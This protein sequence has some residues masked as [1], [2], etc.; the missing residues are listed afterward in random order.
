M[1]TLITGLGYIGSALAQRLLRSGE[2]VVGIENFFST[3]REAVAALAGYGDFRLVDGSVDDSACLARAFRTAPIARVVHLAGQASADPSAAPLRYTIDTYVGGA[4]RLLEGCI[5]HRVDHL[6]FAS[7]TRI[8]APPLPS[9]TT[10]EAPLHA[11]DIVHV[12]QL[13]AESMLATALQ[14]HP[15]WSVNALT[16]RIGNVHGRGPVMKDDP[17]F[18]GVA[19]RFC[20]LAA[21]RQPLRASTAPSS[22]LA[23]V[24]LDDVV[25]GLIHCTHLQDPP[26][27]ANLATEI[28]SVH[29]VAL[30]VQRLAAER[31]LDVG[32]T[33][34]GPPPLCEA[35]TVQSRLEATGFRPRRTLEDSLDA[36][37][38]H[39]LNR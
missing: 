33:A 17:R 38:D 21:Q 10:E 8:Y 4:L 27:I 15:D 39:Y 28:R 9:H 37:L 36:V 18:L 16:V 2:T 12:A 20:W 3:P 19:Q 35:R 23:F 11:P 31:G 5:E 30:L 25:E 13:C 29:E 6:V 22:I 24:Q 14:Q 7:S 1:A 34:D 32:L 26:A